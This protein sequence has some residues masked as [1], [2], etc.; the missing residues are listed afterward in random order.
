MTEVAEK[1]DDDIILDNMG[2]KQDL[3]RGVD[4]FM[5]FAFG[6]TE[7]GVLVSITSVLT[8]G[9]MTGGPVTMVR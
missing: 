1:N 7:V 6:F 4:A 9:L 5:S 2:Y 3:H 8:Y